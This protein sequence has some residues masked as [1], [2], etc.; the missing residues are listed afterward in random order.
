MGKKHG[1]SFITPPEYINRIQPHSLT[2]RALFNNNKLFKKIKVSI[3]KRNLLYIEQLLTID[4][5]HL[6]LWADLRYTTF[7]Q[8][9]QS[10]VAPH[11][12]KFLEHLL[13]LRPNISREVKPEFRFSATHFK[14]FTP[15]LFLNQPFNV[16]RNNFVAI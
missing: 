12:F 11:W 15:R 6:L 9:L 1:F 4:G 8:G 5:S 14:G 16:K 10:S 7:S 2:I 3:R 13:L